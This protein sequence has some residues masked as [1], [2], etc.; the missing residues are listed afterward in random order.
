VPPKSYSLVEPIM[1]SLFGINNEYWL[2]FY[3]NGNIYDKKYVFVP[4][5]ITEGNFVNIPLV[6]K[7]G[8]MIK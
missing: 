6:D 3:L 8:V 4:E 1:D 7:Q 2:S 5:S